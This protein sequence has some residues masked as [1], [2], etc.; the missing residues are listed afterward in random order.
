[1]FI[2]NPQ[3]RMTAA[4]SFSIFHQW[5]IADSTLPTSPCAIILH[6][7]PQLSGCHL[8]EEIADYLNEYDDDGE[9]RWLPATAE[10]VAKVA[11]DDNYRLLLG[12]PENTTTG[13]ADLIKTLTAL[14]RRGHVVFQWPE[15]AE[16]CL[17]EI[18]TFHAGVG[19]A[20]NIDEKCHLILNPELIEFNNIAHIIGDVFLE[21]HNSGFRRA[22]PLH[23]IE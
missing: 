3:D 6:M 17:G 10:L 5:L 13:T 7:Q 22:A 19:Q 21:W 23:G 15:S 1:M 8:I 2:M 9:G 4:T 12:I 11:A 16:N 18:Q 20:A 14:G